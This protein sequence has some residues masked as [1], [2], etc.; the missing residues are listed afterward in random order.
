MLAETN[1]IKQQG[2]KEREVMATQ[3]NPWANKAL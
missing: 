2:G 3:A 1:L